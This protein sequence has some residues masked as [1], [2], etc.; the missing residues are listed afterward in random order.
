MV[1]VDTHCHLNTVA[2]YPDLDEVLL[3]ARDAGVAAFLV[4]GI[5]S[6]QTPIALRLAEQHADVYAVVG[7]HPNSVSGF[8]DA[9]RDCF[10][11]WMHH[12][13]VV[14]I[15]ETGLDLYRDHASLTDQIIALEWHLQRACET[16]LPVV[17]HCRHAYDHLLEALETRGSGV[18][19]VMHCFSGTVEHA[20]RALALGLYL[21]F[22][23]P[24]TYKNAQLTREIVRMCPADRILLET[25]CPYLPPEPYRGKRNEPSYLP[26]IA[27]AV[28][29]ARGETVEQVAKQTT[30]NAEALFGIT[31]PG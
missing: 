3:R 7:M 23:G 4:V 30:R 18:R 29:S 10:A 14:A 28:A 25:D 8:D 16:G 27:A 5:D 9:L 24:V 21:G 6:E 22:D 12:P 13:R 19:G 31:V 17:F 2:S 15:G 20:E 1:L 11:E 26:L